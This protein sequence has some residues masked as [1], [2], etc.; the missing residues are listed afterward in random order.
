MLAPGIL[1]LSAPGDSRSEISTAISV[2][3]RR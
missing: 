3:V 1:D 2:S